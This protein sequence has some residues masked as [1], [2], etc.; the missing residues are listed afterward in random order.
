V[1]S[2]DAERVAGKKRHTMTD[3]EFP[4]DYRLTVFPF[5]RDVSASFTV[6]S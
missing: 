3:A 1:L 4:C 6:I 2:A 5:T